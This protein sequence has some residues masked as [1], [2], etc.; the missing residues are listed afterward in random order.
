M[1]AQTIE[2]RT[3]TKDAAMTDAT[4][5]AVVA[6][7]YGS[8]DVLELREMPRP[9]PAADEILIEIEAVAVHAGDWHLLRADPFLI[10]LMFGLT[11]PKNP[12][13]GAD[14]A[15]RVVEVGSEVTEFAV[16]DE[17]MGD[18][19]GAGMGAFAERTS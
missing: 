2:S 9:R 14:L 16:G 7:R 12:I 13:L 11:K 3:P 15:G 4:M 10:R 19:S 6:P 8:P 17:V 18:V 5:R 1:Y